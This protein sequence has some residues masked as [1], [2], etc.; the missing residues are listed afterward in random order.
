MRSVFGV[1]EGEAIFQGAKKPSEAVPSGATIT[2]TAA[3]PYVGLAA[4]VLK[5]KGC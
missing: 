3:I 1:E 5:E 4:G 2:T